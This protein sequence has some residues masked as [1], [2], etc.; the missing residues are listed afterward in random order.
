MTPYAALIGR[1]RQEQGD[2]ERLVSRV[3]SLITKA[4]TT[5]D[6]GYLDGVAL[7]LHGFYTG[8]ERIFEDIARR[9]DGDLPSGPDWHKRLLMQMSAEIPDVRPPVIGQTTKD[10]LEN[11][12]AF[13]HIIRNVY[14][15]NFQ[16][17]RIAELADGVRGCHERV[18][19]DLGEFGRFLAALG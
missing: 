4:K 3:E 18:V 9:L 14:T 11:Y 2:L 7:N 16:F 19:V 1:M 15:F 12:R 5:G 8:V 6:D 17:S 10:C 13:R